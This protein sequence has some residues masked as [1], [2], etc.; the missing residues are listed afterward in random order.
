MAFA[1]R[2]GGCDAVPLWRCET[3]HH[4]QASDA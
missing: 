1:Q 4:Q 2:F 3:I